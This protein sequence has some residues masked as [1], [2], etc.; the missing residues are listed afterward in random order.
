MTYLTFMFLVLYVTPINDSEDLGK[1]K[2]K[3]RIFVGYAPIKKAYQIYN[4]RTHLIIETIHV[5]FDELTTMA[6]K[7]FSLRSGP[8]LLTPGTL[9]S[10]LIPNPP[11]PTPGYSHGG[12]IKLDEDPQGK[13][14]DPTRYHGMIGSFMYRTSTF[15]KDDYAGCQD[16]YRS[17]SG[18]YGFGFN[19][20]PLYCDNKSAIALCF[21][22]IQHSRSNHI[23]IRYHFIKEKVENRVVELCVVRTEYQLANIFTK[24]LGQERLEFLTNNLGMRSIDYDQYL[25]SDASLKKTVKG[26]QKKTLTATKY[27][28]V[29]GQ[30]LR[31]GKWVMCKDK[32]KIIAHFYGF[33]MGGHLGVYATTK[34]LTT[35]FYWKGLMKMVKQWIRT[36]FTI[37]QGK[38]NKFL[39]MFFGPFQVIKKIGAVAYKLKLPSHAMI[40]LVFHVSQLKAC[41]FDVNEMGHFP[42]CDAEGMIAATLFKLPERRIAKQGNK[43]LVFGLI[44][45]S[46]GNKEDATLEV[47]SDIV[48]IFL[49]FV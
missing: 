32:D 2:P 39:A 18:N 36:Q 26:L 47:L 9:S 20:I 27:E 41:H 11:S 4:K 10:V 42:Q 33:A 29:N 14:V 17:T 21:N 46:N 7:Q 22:N 38:Q 34:R 43:V 40:H 19:K 48:K 6:S 3:I 15:A 23:D 30:L 8:Q 45:W 31:K 25:D 1:L 13:A 16:T 12:E 24:T 35:F 49:E 28:W 44:Q 5:T 37:R